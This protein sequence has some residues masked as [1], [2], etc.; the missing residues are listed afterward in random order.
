[1]AQDLA[2]SRATGLIPEHVLAHV[3]GYVAGGRTALAARLPGGSV[4]TSFRVDT[5]AGR[6]V[7]RLHDAAANLLGANHEREAKLHAAAVAAGLAPAL[8]HVDPAHHFMIM[9]YVEGPTWTSHDF[10]RPERLN[11]LGAALHVLH[12]VPPP[13]VAPFDMADE[14]A[15][16]HGRLVDADPGERSRLAPLMDRAAAALEQSAQ[17]RRPRTLVHN[18]LHHT[19]LIGVERLHLLDWEYGAVTDPLLDLACVLAYYPQAAAHAE[20]LLDAAHLRDSVT[21]EMLRATT[22]LS[23]LV[24]CLWYRARRLAGEVPAADRAIEQGLWDR[25]QP[26]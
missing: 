5:S 25:L 6:F 21:P 1:M 9:E 20:T 13:A 2:R 24:S 12:S 11:Q 23:V 3:P 16:H 15:R 10:A 17:H 22:W 7:V 8:I 18:D 14:L 4:N 26:A 19:N